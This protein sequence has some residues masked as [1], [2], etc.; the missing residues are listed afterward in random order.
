LSI[1]QVHKVGPS[2]KVVDRAKR[3]LNCLSLNALAAEP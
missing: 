3:N 2:C 1:Y